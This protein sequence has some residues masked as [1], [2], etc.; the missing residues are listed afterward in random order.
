[1][2]ITGW[3]RLRQ[4]YGVVATALAL[5]GRSHYLQ[6]GESSMMLLGDTGEKLPRWFAQYD[7]GVKIDYKSSSFIKGGMGIEDYIVQNFDIKLSGE[8]W[9]LLKCLYLSENEQDIIECY[10]L[11]EGMSGLLPQIVQQLSEACTSVKVKRLF[12]FMAEM[13]GHAWVKYI[14]QELL[15]LGAGKRSIIPNR[16]YVQKFQITVPKELIRGEGI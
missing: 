1:M 7:W 5:L 13:T 15:D 2:K 11:L 10:E 9:V 6:M 8:V 3:C 16:A 4:L 12:L 14:K